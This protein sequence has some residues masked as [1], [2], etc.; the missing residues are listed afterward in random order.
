MDSE[1]Q[2]GGEQLL[3]AWKN[4]PE[5]T[6]FGKPWKNEKNEKNPKNQ[7]DQ[8]TKNRKKRGGDDMENEKRT[9]KQVQVQHLSMQ[10]PELGP[11]FHL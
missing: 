6:H 11:E 7:K 8:R 9:K 1:D 5:K 4:V 10:L 3:Q 2:G